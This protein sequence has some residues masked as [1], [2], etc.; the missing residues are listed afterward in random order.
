MNTPKTNEK[1]KKKDIVSKEIANIKNQMEI[2]ELKN[3]R[4]LK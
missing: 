4:A 1:K 2:L 3:T